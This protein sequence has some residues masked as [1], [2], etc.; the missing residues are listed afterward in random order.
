MKNRAFVFG[1]MLLHFAFAFAFAL[2]AVRVCVNTGH[3]SNA[4]GGRHV[5]E[6][7]QS[8][9]LPRTHFPVTQF[10]SHGLAGR[11]WGERR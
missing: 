8:A 5:G 3:G 2:C 4:A 11:W 1:R 10:D 9:L 7:A 6:R